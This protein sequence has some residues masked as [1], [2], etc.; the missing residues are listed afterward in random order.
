MPVTI[1]ATAGAS[2][3]NSYATHA[4]A[5]AYFAARVALSPPWLESG[6][7]AARALVMAARVLDSLSAGRR[8]LYPRDEY[9]GQPYYKTTRAWTG[10]VATATQSMAWPR[11]GMY[12]R[13]GRAVA[14]N[15]VPIELKEAQ[16]ELAG[17]LLAADRTLD[18]DVA[19][20]GITS[21]KAGSVEVKFKE[22]IARQVLPGSVVDLLVPS[23]LTDEVITP[24]TRASFAAL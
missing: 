14:E 1:V 6:D 7:V 4:E 22:L 8:R 16:A 3:A 10:A 23:W 17:A 15:V 24:A 5:N 19:L 13:L 9:N 20:Q 2:N 12:D 11:I 21:V 18:N